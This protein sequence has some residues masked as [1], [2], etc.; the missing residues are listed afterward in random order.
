PLT[1]AHLAVSCRA[2]HKPA[3]KGGPLR[4]VGTETRCKTCHTDPHGSQ[5]AAEMSRGDCTSCHRAD[6]S[7]FVIR[8]FDHEKLAGY[9]LKG[10][11]AGTAC[12]SCHSG[13]AYRG[14]PTHCGSCHVDPH[15]GQLARKGV[16]RCE[17]CHASSTAW[18]IPS[19]DHTRHTRFPLDKA[20]AKVT[21]A[22]CHPSVRQPD[23]S[24]V[25][26]YRPLGTECRSCH[27]FTSR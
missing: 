13:G 17:S 24:A 18:S 22:E 20:H 12:S 9:A 4:F 1:G 15:R 25:V 8:P 11:H 2:C 21:C 26:Q 14:T 27:E 23:G 10:A 6:S 3:A 16:T 19:F 7:T 5:F